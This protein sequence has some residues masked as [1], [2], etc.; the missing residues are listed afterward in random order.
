MRLWVAK[1]PL[2][3]EKLGIWDTYPR[4][5]SQASEVETK[6]KNDELK[7]FSHF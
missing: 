4:A 2:F 6:E 5:F 1:K 3:C 7:F